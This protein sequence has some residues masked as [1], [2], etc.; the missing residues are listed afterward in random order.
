MFPPSGALALTPLSERLASSALAVI[1]ATNGGD[2][3]ES[4]PPRTPQQRP[5]NGFEDPRGRVEFRTGSE[6]PLTQ[7]STN[8]LGVRRIVF[9]GHRYVTSDKQVRQG[10]REWTSCRVSA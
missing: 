6:R 10:C 4:N 2:G 7:W 8:R 1:C 9:R 5:A 3:C